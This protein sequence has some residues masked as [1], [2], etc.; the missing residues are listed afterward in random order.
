[1]KRKKSSLMA[2]Q[3][4]FN[5]NLQCS[6]LFL[7]NIYIFFWVVSIIK[8]TKHESVCFCFINF[9]LLWNQMCILCIK[10]IEIIHRRTYIY[11]TMTLCSDWQG[12]SFWGFVFLVP[13]RVPSQ[14]AFNLEVSVLNWEKIPLKLEIQIRNWYCKELKLPYH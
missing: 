3:S 4:F 9:L 13:T 11:Q 2:D 6:V 14:R 8:K 12:T 5:K 1:M 10:L 7:W